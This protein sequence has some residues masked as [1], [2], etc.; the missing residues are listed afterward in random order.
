[1]FTIYNN[2]DCGVNATCIFAENEVTAGMCKINQSD[3]P[4]KFTLRHVTVVP[5]TIDLGLVIPTKPSGIINE[6]M[7]D[8][9]FASEG[10]VCSQSLHCDP[11]LKCVVAGAVSG[12]TTCQVVCENLVCSTGQVCSTDGTCVG[13][14][15]SICNVN[16][17]NVPPCS[18]TFDCVETVA[19]LGEAEAV[20]TC[21]VVCEGE[22]CGTANV[23]SEEGAC[24]G[25]NGAVCSLG[26]P[27]ACMINFQCLVKDTDLSEDTGT[28]SPFC[29]EDSDCGENA[30]CTFAENEV[31][32]ICEI[33]TTVTDAPGT[34][35]PP[36]CRVEQAK[37]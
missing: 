4:S 25:V 18:Q 26:N 21:Q 37:N 30:T 7:I 29:K 19:A 15:G 10:M 24:V 27:N 3:P 22:I 6:T 20:T 17:N 2:S 28:C 5:Y 14:D 9:T 16:D 8:K 31:S 35:S 1:M 33:D 36:K 34:K 32:G 11:F 13:G 23:C 12:V